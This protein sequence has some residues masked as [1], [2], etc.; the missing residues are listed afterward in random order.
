MTLPAPTT[1]E[2]LT[3]I[4]MSAR[5]AREMRSR[6]CQAARDA[7]GMSRLQLAGGKGS[8]R[9]EVEAMSQQ[10]AIMAQGEAMTCVAACK[11]LDEALK[12]EAS[13]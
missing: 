2:C 11:M 1:D 13:E 6:A 4:E 5:N 9:D 10:F 8:D 3:L 12:G 7:E